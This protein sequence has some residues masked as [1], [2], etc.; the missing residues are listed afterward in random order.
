MSDFKPFDRGKTQDHEGTK[1]KT[2]NPNGH[3]QPGSSIKISKY[4]KLSKY[5]LKL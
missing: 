2:I 3:I 5:F 1:K 4:L